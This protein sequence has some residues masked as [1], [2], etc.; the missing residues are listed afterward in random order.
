MQ[1]AIQG[2]KISKAKE[3]IKLVM[4][5]PNL[6]PLS[7]SKRRAVKLKYRNQDILGSYSEL[8]AHEWHSKVILNLC[9]SMK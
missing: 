8:R 7:V 3:K 6:F 1:K 2:K 9:S 5:W 4:S